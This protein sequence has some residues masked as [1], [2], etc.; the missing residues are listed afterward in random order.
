MS[1]I[2]DNKLI[3]PGPLLTVAKT[4][5][6]TEDGEP[7]GTLFNLNLIGTLLAYKGSPT[8][9]GTLWTGAGEP[10][11]ETVAANER[12]KSI[13]KKQEALRQ[14]FS[15]HGKLLEITPLDGSAPVQC[16]PRIKGITFQEGVWY[17]K[18]DYN[19]EMDADI[20]LGLINPSGEDRFSQF[21][22]SANEKWTI[23]NNDTP[24][25]ESL[26][27]TYRLT[28]E[29]NAVGKRFFNEAG[30]LVKPAWQQAQSWVLPRLGIDSARITASG[31]LNLP[32][33]YAGYNHVRSELV[34][35]NDGSYSVSETWILA[36]G[37]AIED[38]TV[39]IRTSAEDAISSATIEGSIQGLE[40]RDSNYALT[41][42]K[43][44]SASSRFTSVQSLLYSRV[45]TYVGGGFNVVPLSTQIGKNPIAGTIN[46]TYEY[47]NRPSN[48]IPGSKSEQITV[49]WD[50]QSDVFASIFVLG[51]SSPILQDLNAS[52]AKSISLSVEVIMDTP[53]NSLLTGRPDYSAVIAA[54]QP[55]G[56]SYISNNRETWSSKTSRGSRQM[57]FVYE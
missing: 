42:S 8:S 44:Q 47:N 1:V 57:T 35:E 54:V 13:L 53:S 12:L 37:S 16:N 34:G 55:A 21:I 19:V 28:H 40:I 7:I 29:V 10:P 23:E 56:T 9:S 32:S 38:F 46:Y 48:L 3:S 25:N 33:Y 26:S 22:S 4:Y 18:C 51:R 15:N 43:Y 30:T 14:L 52:T 2:Y 5:S 31:V 36:S 6:F 39:S 45:N 20:L 41:T 24:E 50:H 49:D 27:Q 17:D 11:E